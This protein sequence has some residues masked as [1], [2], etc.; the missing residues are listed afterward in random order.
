MRILNLPYLTEFSQG[1]N[2]LG[3][4]VRIILVGNLPKRSRSVA[5]EP[6]KIYFTFYKQASKLSGNK[7]QK[8]DKQL[9]YL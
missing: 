8:L 3:S 5:Y 6:T 9:N 2:H 7:V 4:F 1:I